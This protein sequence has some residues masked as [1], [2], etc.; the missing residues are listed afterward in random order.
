MESTR[1]ILETKMNLQVLNISPIKHSHTFQ[2]VII[3][4]T[5]QK[6]TMTVETDYINNQPLQIIQGDDHFH[7]FFQWH[8]ELAEKVY[9]LVHQVSNQQKLDFPIS[10][11]EFSELIEPATT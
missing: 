11:G 5:Q 2:V 10:L 3:G 4:L 8:R 9:A 6:F 1:R 7:T